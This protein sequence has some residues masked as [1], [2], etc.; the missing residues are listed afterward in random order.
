MGSLLISYGLLAGL[1]RYL[2]SHWDARDRT[3]LMDVEW[4]HLSD[5]EDRK[6]VN[7]WHKH[8]LNMFSKWTAL[9]VIYFGLGIKLILL[10]GVL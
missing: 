8:T 6:Y 3:Y 2:W 9:S 4:K 10:I 7:Q 1:L 5:E